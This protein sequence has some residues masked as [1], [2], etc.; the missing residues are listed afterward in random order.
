MEDKKTLFKEI[1]HLALPVA[2][3]QFMIALVSACDAVMLGRLDQDAMSSVSLATQVTFVFNLFMAAFVI[4]ENM[5]VAQYY[6]KKDFGAISRVCA[7]V[8]RLSLMTA[9]VFCLGTML[10]PSY[11]MSF[12]TN[13][14]QLIAYGSEYLRVVGISYLFSAVA[15]VCMTLMKNCGAVNMSTVV[16]SLAVILN[17]IFNALLIFGLCGLPKMGI[18]GAALATVLAA[19]IQTT[20]SL[21]YVLRHMSHIRL[22]VF[23]REKRL[24]QNFRQRVVPVL[25]NEL[26]WGGGVTMFSVIMGHLGSDAVA[27]Q[28]IANISKNLI[29]CFCIGLGAAGSIIIGNRLGADRFEEAKQAGGLL[30]KIAFI[31][32][33]M[34]GVILLALSPLIVHLMDLTPQAG[35]YLKGM[36][37][38]SSYY[39]IGKSLNS[40][41]VGGIFPAGGDS[42][43]GM[44]CDTVTLWCIVVPLGALCA[45]VWKLPVMAV[46]FVLSLD[47]I[48]KLPVVFMHYKKY[49]WVKN[50]T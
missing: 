11:I 36:L 17:I 29:V 50:I 49:K 5:F 21:L 8:L 27:A 19:V 9:L 38:I 28:G 30:V 39:L 15:Q 44:F 43:F 20:W 18:A 34:T 24:N 23:G 40:M 13:D 26:F 1:W 10:V 4:G 46:Y 22:T 32:G 3:S 33:L 12:F 48:I 42:K 7:L 25:L 31:S 14:A 16:S 37:G 2:F 45:F 47:E 41:T 6:G 35:S